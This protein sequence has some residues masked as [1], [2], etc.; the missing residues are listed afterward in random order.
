VKRDKI[1]DIL[2]FIRLGGALPVMAILYFQFSYAAL[3]DLK[4]LNILLFVIFWAFAST[5]FFDGLI[6][7]RIG[8]T[9]SFGILFDPVADKVIILGPLIIL[10][11]MDRGVHLLPVLIMVLREIIITGLRSVAAVRGMVIKASPLGK[12]KMLFQELSVGF[13][14]IEGIRILPF[15]STKLLAQIF[16]WTAMAVSVISGLEYFLG[17]LK[18]RKGETNKRQVQ[19]K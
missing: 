19:A 3:R 1:P 4:W 15:I 8:V 7:R 17:F 10:L 2:T 9:S 16:L 12:S 18:F 13:F 6:A 14:I 5:D 11:Q